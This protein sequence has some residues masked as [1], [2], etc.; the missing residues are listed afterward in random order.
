MLATSTN[1]SQFVLQYDVSTEFLPSIG[2]VKHGECLYTYLSNITHM[3]QLSVYCEL[4]H[5]VQPTPCMGHREL[6]DIMFMWCATE[7]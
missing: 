2:K 7:G 3:H 6:V 1:V 5:I 4:L